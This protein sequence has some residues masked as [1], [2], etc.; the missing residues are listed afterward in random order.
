MTH[1]RAAKAH[2]AAES[3]TDPSASAP[4]G[5]DNALAALDYFKAALIA[6]LTGGISP[7]A[8]ALAMAD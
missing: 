4:P 6:Q 7:S 8:L 3:V 1:V 5:A 2:P